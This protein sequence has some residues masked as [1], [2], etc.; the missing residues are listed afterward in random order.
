MVEHRELKDYYKAVNKDSGEVKFFISTI[1]LKNFLV[2]NSNWIP[3][4]NNC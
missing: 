4:G 2:K 3:R 1:A